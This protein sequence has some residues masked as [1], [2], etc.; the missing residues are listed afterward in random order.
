LESKLEVFVDRHNMTA[1][2]FYDQLL[3][4]QTEDP[5]ASQIIQYLLG[6]TEYRRFVDL[7][8]DRKLFHFGTGGPIGAAVGAD[9]SVLEGKTTDGDGGE[10]NSS[11]GSNSSSSSSS[12]SSEGRVRNDERGNSGSSKTR[13]SD[14]EDR[15]TFG[16]KESEERMASSVG[17]KETDDTGQDSTSRKK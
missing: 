8:I 7:L 6:A 10:N 9:G 13:D 1:H 2:S 12:T 5:M 17:G 16:R 3:E 15:P 14:E 11:S 4:A